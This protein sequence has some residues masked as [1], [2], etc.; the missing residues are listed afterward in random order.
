MVKGDKTSYC[1]G[2]CQA[3]ADTGTSLI[4]GPAEEVKKLNEKLGAMEVQGEVGSFVNNFSPFSV[5]KF[6]I[7]T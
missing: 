2:G 1:A 4:T 5:N 6:F 7:F 3:I